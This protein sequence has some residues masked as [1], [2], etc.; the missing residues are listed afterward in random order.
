MAQKVTCWVAVG[1]WEGAMNKLRVSRVVG[2]RGVDRSG[3]RR[4]VLGW[5]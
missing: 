5:E 1:C 3:C 2:P 4:G